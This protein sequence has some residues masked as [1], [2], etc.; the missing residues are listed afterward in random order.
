[1]IYKTK[2]L[3][4]QEQATERFVNEPY[5]ALFCEMG[6][7]K[8]KIILD[9]F[10]NA[11]K[12]V[13]VLVIAPNGLHHNWAKNEIPKHADK[14]DVYCWNGPPTSKKKQQELTRFYNLES[15]NK[16]FLINVEALRTKSGFDYANAFLIGSHGTERHIVVDESTCIKNPKAQQTKAVMKLAKQAERKWILNGTPITQGPLDLF[17]QCKFLAN[18]ALPYPTM[19]SFKHAYAVETTMT[20][21]N[22]SFRKIVGYQNLDKLTKSLEPFSLRLEKKDCLDLPEKTFNQVYVELTP[23]QER[24]YKQ[25]KNDCIS[26]LENGDLITTT[27]ALTKIVKLHQILTGFVIT[28]SDLAV[29]LKNNRIAALEQICEVAKPVVVFCAYKHNVEQI[30]KELGKSLNIVTYTG[31]DATTNRNQAVEDFQD[32]K[33]DVFLATSAAAKGLTL[34][35]AS[36]MVYY[37]NNYSLETRL[38]SQ[39]RIHR[40]GQDNKC[41]YIDLVVPNTIDE[42]ILKRLEEKKELSNEVLDDLIDIIKQ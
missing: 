4:H 28:D 6:T 30:Q 7:G 38:Q 20:M 42:A 29:D 12:P 11:K 34:T 5:G 24:V 41:T 3:Q 16:Y 25:I 2:P 18:D 15:Y 22:R 26:L 33:A 17:S 23:E 35:R 32:G 1:M 10:Q 21:G 13:S 14:A 9:V 39:D 36:T 8:T 19:T 31:N 40:I 27:M 37:S